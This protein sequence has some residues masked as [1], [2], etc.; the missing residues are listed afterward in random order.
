[1]EKLDFEGTVYKPKVLRWK[2]TLK[3]LSDQL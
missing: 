2:E 3:D 1:M